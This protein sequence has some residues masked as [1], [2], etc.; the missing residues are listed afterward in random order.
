MCNK[1]NFRT[2]GYYTYSICMS[3]FDMVKATYTVY[4]FKLI[5][6]EVSVC[7]FSEIR[8]IYSMPTRCPVMCEQQK[9][10]I[11]YTCN[12]QGTNSFF[13]MEFSFNFWIWWLRV[14]TS[15]FILFLVNITF[16]LRDLSSFYS[17]RN[18]HS[19]KYLVVTADI[20]LEAN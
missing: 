1:R 2:L 17:D 8:Y 16:G 15:L 9:I 3:T 13:L 14:D 5:G 20:P 12:G 6:R 7:E 11:Q 18:C 4:V 10:Q 19:R